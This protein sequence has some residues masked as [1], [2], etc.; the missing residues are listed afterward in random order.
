MNQTLEYLK[1]CGFEISENKYDDNFSPYKEI[2]HPYSLG[3]KVFKYTP[4]HAQD[5]NG[6]HGTIIPIDSIGPKKEA[7]SEGVNA[8]SEG[9][10]AKS[11]GTNTKSEGANAKCVDLI[12]V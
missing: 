7:K 3:N 1:L 2:T 5:I 8:K 9:A 11:E 10:N 12:M 4:E 6:P